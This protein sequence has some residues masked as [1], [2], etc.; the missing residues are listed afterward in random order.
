MFAVLF[1]A[2]AAIID[3]SPRR[4]ASSPVAHAAAYAARPQLRTP[5]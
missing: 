1:E 5:I 2:I 4:R 3:R